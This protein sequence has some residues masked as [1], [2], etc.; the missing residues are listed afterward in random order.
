MW[1]NLPESFPGIELDLYVIMPNHFHGIVV[2]NDSSV[3]DASIPEYTLGQII[4]TFKARASYYIHE[5]GTKDFHWQQKYWDSIIRDERHLTE[6]RQYII[7]N[8]AKWIQDKL[9]K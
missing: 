3:S 4:R 1:N 8:P 9:Y 7:N 6:I 2:L 5:A